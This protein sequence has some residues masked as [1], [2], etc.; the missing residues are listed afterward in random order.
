MLN[1]TIM[2]L[3]V[4]IVCLLAISAVSAE[5]DAAGNIAGT[6][7][8][9]NE[10]DSTG[11]AVLGSSPTD[12]LKNEE[13]DDGINKPLS[14]DTDSN[15]LKKGEDQVLGN[16]I[17]VS[18]ENFTDIEK[19]IN[20]SEDGDIIYLQGG[21]YKGNQSINITKNLTIIGGFEKGDGIYATLDA[22]QL[23]RIFDIN[24]PV[25]LQGIKFI[26][27]NSTAGGAILVNNT[28][29]TL[30]DC[31]F[32]NN[33]ASAYG[34]A[35]LWLSNSKEIIDDL[36]V[37][38]Y[39]NVG[40][41]DCIFENNTAMIGGANAFLCSISN[42]TLTGTFNN[43]SAE[44]MGG[45]NLFWA[46][47]NVTL[48]GT[49]N[50]NHAENSGGANTFMEALNVTVAGTFNNNSAGGAGGANAF[51]YAVNVTVNGNFFN[52]TARETGAAN[53][54]SGAF[55]VTVTGNFIQNKAGSGS[56]NAFQHAINVSLSGNYFYNEGYGVIYISNSEES[57][58]RDAIFIN[59]F[60]YA[61]LAD[62]VVGEPI[63]MFNPP[64]LVEEGS[65]S[66]F[67]I[68]FGNN[69]TDYDVD[70]FEKYNLGE[71]IYLANWLFL[72]ATAEPNNISATDTTKI[73]FMLSRYDGE[74]ISS[75]DNSRLL[76]IDLEIN[77]TLGNVNPNVANLNESI[78]FTPYS[79]GNGRV[80]ASIGDVLCAI[81]VEILKADPNWTIY[82]YDTYI[83][84]D[85]GIYII[86]PSDAGGNVTV[87]LSNGT[88]HN[89]TVKDGYVFLDIPNLPLGNN[90]VIITYSGDDK[91]SEKTNETV[92]NVILIETWVMAESIEMYEGD[93]TKFMVTLIDGRER[94]VA[95]MGI[96]VTIAGKTYTIITDE[97]GTA[98]LPINLKAGIYPVTS[99][100]NGKGNYS[101]SEPIQENVTVGVMTKVRIDKHKDMTKDYG[102]S[103]KFT[104]HAVDKYGR[105]VG[106]WAK[107]KMTIAGKTY[108]VF[109]DEKGY[110]SIAINLKPGTYD[111]TC[112]YAGYTVKHKITVKQVLSATNRQYKKASSYPFTAT[113][114]HS[115]GKAIS[116]K[117][118]TFTFKGKTYTQTTNAKGEATINIK[119]A[120][121]IGTHNIAITY[122]DSTIKKTITIK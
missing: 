47:L 33:Y 99:V 48:N 27:G 38:S 83:G 60:M 69:A 68:W 7:S 12:D 84:D 89:G 95:G 49:F 11:G 110:A 113:L 59:N 70:P 98:V 16:E 104:I 71:N 119:E 56:A 103:D 46:A 4:F 25:T 55:N 15:K 23:S 117:T 53:A 36:P 118:V 17:P 92:I 122:L 39:L 6:E 44:E 80:T 77:S 52:N 41:V 78:T 81:E 2:L 112:E 97:N 58:V 116:G 9:I 94:P 64:I 76:P 54:F 75:Y 114:K 102:D 43:N 35:V 73:I 30:I 18:G 51:G 106:A 26:N 24:A 61:I 107:V 67:D 109:T 40:I 31:I 82:V 121:G 115:D 57:N 19:A 32:T 3:S 88:K 85:A 20:K 22:Q 5:S 65:I 108:T 10:I 105:S 111:I 45:A 96:K 14:V 13:K 8:S 28:A 72:N 42:V 50:N 120:L 93:G 90:S 74:K 79:A 21:Y 86:F 100:F 63:V 87:T 101:K 66:A 62:D 34:G 91:Y 1:K 37:L 29:C